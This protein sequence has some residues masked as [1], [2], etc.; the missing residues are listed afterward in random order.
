MEQLTGRTRSRTRIQGEENESENTELSS[1]KEA[2]DGSEVSVLAS[3]VKIGEQ[4]ADGQAQI[5]AQLRQNQIQLSEA[6]IR[7]TKEN[8][9]LNE[10]LRSDISVQ[11]DGLKSSVA[12]EI[13]RL[14]SRTE[15]INRLLEHQTGRLDK[16][17][18]A[19]RDQLQDQIR[20][21]QDQR[22][23]G[24]GR[25]VETLL[26]NS[27]PFVPARSVTDADRCQPKHGQRVPKFTGDAPWEAYLVQFHLMAREHAWTDR[28]KAY[29]LC[30]SLE[31]PA[32][33]V[34][35]D[36]SEH[37]CANFGLLAG[38]LEKRFSSKYQQQQDRVKLAS[39]RRTN[40][41]IPKL[42][43]EIE[44]MVRAAYPEADGKVHQSLTLHHLSCAVDLNMQAELLRK[45]PNT[46][47]EAIEVLTTEEA[48]RAMRGARQAQPVRA[49]LVHD[50]SSEP[51][52]DHVEKLERELSRVRRELQV[53]EQAGQGI[54]QRWTASSAFRGDCWYCGKYRHRRRD[55]HSAKR[56]R[57]QECRQTKD[58][59]EN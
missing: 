39:Y 19:V 4:M 14:D 5:S 2:S 48:I 51:E 13:S 22:D 12:K 58:A 31:G 36:I 47:Q 29:H 49:A 23:D 24:L 25:R 57:E 40:E 50:A 20:A 59:S 52:D 55:C 11:L 15:S 10:A 21:L 32:L 9:E 18:A 17:L 54:R 41:T 8:Q 34:L 35:R 38:A 7:Q 56:D 37:D 16:E 33:T 27:E 3:V 30:M 26:A 28:E 44:R 46:V 45:N 43:G 42:V 53:A 1:E 6:M